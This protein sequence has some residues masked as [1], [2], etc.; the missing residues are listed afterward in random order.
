MKEKDFSQLNK[1]VNGI[2]MSCCLLVSLLL[3]IA[4]GLSLFWLLPE[5]RSSVVV[6]PP[7]WWFFFQVHY[8]LYANVLYY[9]RKPNGLDSG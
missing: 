3:L 9:H 7:F 1:I 4:P 5:Y 8:S 2:L 6:V